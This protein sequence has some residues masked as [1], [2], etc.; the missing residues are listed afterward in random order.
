MKNYILLFTY[1]VTLSACDNSKN[2][3]PKKQEIITMNDFSSLVES[4]RDLVSSYKFQNEKSGVKFIFDLYS[5]YSDP[6]NQT[7]EKE[8]TGIYRNGTNISQAILKEGN[9]F[10]V[11]L[12]DYIDYFVIDESNN[13]SFFQDDKNVID[14]GFKVTRIK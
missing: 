13:T 4:S 8:F 6:E 3:K 10:T 7:G 1:I 5:G 14:L 2:E 12:N 9:K 11:S